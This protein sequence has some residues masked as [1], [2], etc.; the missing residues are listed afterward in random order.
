MHDPAAP[1]LFSPPL[2]A[3]AS[4]RVGVARDAGLSGRLEAD[5]GPALQVT[6]G[7][8]AGVR[9]GGDARLSLSQR[10]GDR[11]ELGVAGRAE[12][13]A[14]AYARFELSARAALLF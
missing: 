5:A 9:L 13:V 11:V 8:G 12:R 6:T 3:S 7:A 10:L 1:R 2:F 14:N 4:P